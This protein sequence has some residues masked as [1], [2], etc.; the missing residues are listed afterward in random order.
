[1]RESE[2]TL[3][4]GSLLTSSPK[5]YVAAPTEARLRT[6]ASVP[7][8][9]KHI[10]ALLRLRRESG[11]PVGVRWSGRA[12]EHAVAD[13]CGGEGQGQ[14]RGI[15]PLMNSFGRNRGLHP[16][17]ASNSNFAR[18]AADHARQEKTKLGFKR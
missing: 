5:V 14:D 3:H 17:R 1:M 10:R 12:F 4:P 8:H 2:V 13:D 18:E 7:V 9:R 11:A 15:V 6:A 16:A